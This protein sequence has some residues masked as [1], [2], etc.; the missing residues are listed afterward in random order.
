M[1][2]CLEVLYQDDYL[3]AVNKPSGL[4]V[5]RSPIDRHETRF[6]LQTV[7]NQ[8]GR[9]VY[10]VHRLDKPTSGVL[11][12]A[13]SP[14]IARS[15]VECFA[16]GEVKKSYLA[17]VRGYAPDE[18]TIDYPLVEDQDKHDHIFT[19]IEK[20]A[21][22]AVTVFR[23]LARIE[24]QSSVGRYAT[25]RYS[26]VSA[27]PRTGRRHQL[28]RHFKHIFHPII[29]DT[30]Y[31]EGRHNRFFREEFGV[32]RLLLHAAELMFPHPITGAPVALIAPLDHEFR[33]LMERLGWLAA[34]PLEWRDPARPPHV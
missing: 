30:R 10:P 31:G 11:L 27:A 17:V 20:E 15:L 14:E 26:L 25:S 21:Q 28:R 12:F 4:L 29:G 34:V 7:R 5:H 1:D 33:T 18:G 9:R 8:T 24:L 6:A 13:F 16:A 22:A 23:C 19:G 3:V 2:E 32:H